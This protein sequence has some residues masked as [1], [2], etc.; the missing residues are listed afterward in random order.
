MA[1]TA[2][3]RLAHPTSLD[4]HGLSSMI[5]GRNRYCAQSSIALEKTRSPMQLVN[6]RVFRLGV[7]VAT[8]LATTIAPAE[9]PAKIVAPSRE[10][11][12]L[13]GYSLTRSGSRGD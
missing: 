6:D 7:L 2:S 13:P 11:S 10:V 8:F 4:S 12:A 3:Q 1:L 5:A 9:T